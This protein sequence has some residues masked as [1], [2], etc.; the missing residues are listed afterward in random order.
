[1]QNA[2]STLKGVSAVRAPQITRVR[3]PWVIVRKRFGPRVYAYARNAVPVRPMIVD[4]KHDRRTVPTPSGKQYPVLFGAGATSVLMYLALH[5]KA[6]ATEV[7]EA[8]EI[9]PC[10]FQRRIER[11]RDMKVIVGDWHYAINTGLR[12]EVELVRFLRLLGCAYGMKSA[13]NG[14]GARKPQLRNAHPAAP[15]PPDLFGTKN[16]SRILMLVAALGE[17]YL[18]E[19]HAVLGVDTMSLTQRLPEFV[20]E[21]VLRMRVVKRV[22]CYSLEAAYP[23]AAWLRT[24]LRREATASPEIVR[25]ANN[26][27]ARRLEVERTGTNRERNVFADLYADGMAGGATIWGV[28]RERPPRRRWRLMHGFWNT[29][30][31]RPFG[32]TCGTRTRP[33]MLRRRYL[34]VVRGCRVRA[35]RDHIQVISCAPVRTSRRRRWNTSGRPR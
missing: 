3:G 13:P 1:M 23:G 35:R 15:M 33:A 21:G 27:L 22:K 14:R 9:S 18:Q 16:R 6:K 10:A 8:L 2:L 26:A 28:Q 25:A 20:V 24:Y 7:R 17:T 12:H 29:W 4:L 5:P 31:F 34:D 30:R 32:T 11:L 19:M